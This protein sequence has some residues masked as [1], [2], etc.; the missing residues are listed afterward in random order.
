MM[1]TIKDFYY[2]NYRYLGLYFLVY[3]LVYGFMS[4]RFGMGMEDCGDLDT[5][6]GCAH[7]AYVAY[8][9]W[10]LAFYRWVFGYG[11]CPVVSGIMAGV[12]LAHALVLQTQLLKLS[13]TLA[14]FAYG[15]LYLCCMQWIW[16]ERF[17]M[18]TDGLGFACILCTVAVML[19]QKP[20]WRTFTT[21]AGLVC[22]SIATFQVFFLYF[23]T[24]WLAVELKNWV[25]GETAPRL[26]RAIRPVAALALAS[27]GWII[28]KHIAIAACAV[29]ESVLDTTWAYNSNMTGWPHFFDLGVHEQLM[30]LGHHVKHSGLAVFW[31]NLAGQV[32]TG[33]WIYTTALLPALLLACTVWKRYGAADG[34]KFAL[35]TA[36]LLYLPFSIALILLWSWAPVRVFVAEP[37]VPAALW[38]T[39]LGTARL[40]DHARVLLLA[41]I[42]F[43]NVKGMYYGAIL[44]SNEAYY[45]RVS[46]Q[47]LNHMYLRGQQMALQHGLK[48]CKIVITG[49]TRAKMG[50]D[51]VMRMR[52]AGLL[53]NQASPYAFNDGTAVFDAFARYERLPRLRLATPEE[54][55]KYRSRLQAMGDWPSDTSVA[56]VDGVILIRLAAP[57]G[58]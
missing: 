43:V 33:Q 35:S 56:A 18:I 40:R 27:V 30:C 24:L 38:A 2:R 28:S 39:W 26:A 32:H 55:E 31:E 20:G 34:C 44:G 58:E 42:A 45:F 49:N 19:L 25:S 6:Q 4:L 17:S 5:P 22:C 29:P 10:F 12:F 23:A 14:R 36:C 8:G 51:E 41:G 11:A 15:V 57:A 3:V 16:V 48:D 52:D 9:R 21:A 47:E 1:N 13:S 50:N 46:M 7:Y 53:L 54:E 37:L